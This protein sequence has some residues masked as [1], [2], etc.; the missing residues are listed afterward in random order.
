MNKVSRILLLIILLYSETKGQDIKID[1]YFRPKSDTF[2]F[3][4][5]QSSNTIRLVVENINLDSAKVSNIKD[6]SFYYQVQK[7]VNNRFI[8][9]SDS[10]CYV[11]SDPMLPAEGFRLIDFYK[12]EML[13]VDME[14]PPICCYFKKGN[15]KVRYVFWYELNGVKKTINTAWFPFYINNTMY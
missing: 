4:D 8:D 3:S 11:N 13:A 15:Y 1:T 12:R 9:L 2:N 5:K 14:Y 10:T 7:S 6:L